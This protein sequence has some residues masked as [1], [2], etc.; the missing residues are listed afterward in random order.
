MK[1]VSEKEFGVKYDL[2][3]SSPEK[4]ERGDNSNKIRTGVEAVS[5]G[6]KRS[7]LPKLTEYMS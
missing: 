5:V 3:N 4:Q 6:K 1:K 2:D 7:V